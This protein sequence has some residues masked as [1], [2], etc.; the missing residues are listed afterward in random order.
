MHGILRDDLASGATPAAVAAELNARLASIGI[1][2]CDGGRYDAHWLAVLYATAQIELAFTLVD[3]A[4][5]WVGNRAAN[6][7]YDAVLGQGARRHRAE[8]D[9]VE[10]CQALLIANAAIG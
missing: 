9:A 6:E 3:V 1:V 5:I 4:A 7:R 8:A 10:I 2:W